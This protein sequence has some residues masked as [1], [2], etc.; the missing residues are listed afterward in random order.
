L[1]KSLFFTNFVDRIETIFG[2][3]LCVLL[4]FVYGDYLGLY[5]LLL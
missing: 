4:M 5:W 1:R 2:Y 3:V